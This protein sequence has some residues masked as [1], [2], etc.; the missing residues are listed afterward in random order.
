MGRNK[1]YTGIHL[2]G[3]SEQRL[4]GNLNFSFS[5]IDGA[6]L[7]P[8]L[9]ELAISTTSACSS[10]SFQPSYVLQALGLS[11]ELAKSAVRL[12]I[13]RFTEEKDIKRAITVINT[14]LEKLRSNEKGL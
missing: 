14:Q 9:S 2:N 1:K 13:G 10:A 11:K 4:A 8:A 3:N 6:E 7:L 12:S 5:N